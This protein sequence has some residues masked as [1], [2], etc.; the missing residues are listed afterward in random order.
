MGVSVWHFASLLCNFY[1]PCNNYI[2]DRGRHW[3]YT[4]WGMGYAIV[5]GMGYAALLVGMWAL[6]RRVQALEY[7]LRVHQHVQ[8]VPQ[9]PV[10]TPSPPAPSSPGYT[11]TDAQQAQA[12]RR[13][14][15]QVSRA[16]RWQ[17][18]GSSTKPPSVYR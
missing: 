14:P 12:E 7:A 4:L 11:I 18:A 17:Q 10:V 6:W 13:Q 2:L 16:H 9:T 5:I 15:S 3:S 8:D 1:I